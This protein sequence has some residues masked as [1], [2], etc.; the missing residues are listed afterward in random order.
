VRDGRVL[1][2]AG[3]YVEARVRLLDL[4]CGAGGAAVGYARAGFEVVGVDIEPQ[5]NYPF[6]HHGADAMTFPLEGFDAI[7]ASPPCQHYAPVTRWRGSA[8]NHPDLLQPTIDRLEAAGVPYVVENVPFAPMAPDLILCGS[9]F[10][11]PVRRHRWFLTSWQQ[12]WMTQP[13]AHRAED[14]SF[15][16]GGKQPESVYRDAMGC[17]WMTVAESR[18]AIPPAYCAFIGEAPAAELREAAA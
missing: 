10:G 7:H 14:Y 2:G 8:D 3:S 15:D 11:L 4:F 6:E 13:C 5:P 17:E 16:H 12:A 18:N 9:M 1:V